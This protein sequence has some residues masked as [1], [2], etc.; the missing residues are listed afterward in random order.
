MYLENMYS[1]TLLLGI[2]NCTVHIL[3]SSFQSFWYAQCERT[4]GFQMHGRYWLET[5]EEYSS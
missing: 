1:A 3:K 5:F 2:M 4:A